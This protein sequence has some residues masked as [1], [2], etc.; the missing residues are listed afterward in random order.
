[1]LAQVRP[2]N[3]RACYES[4]ISDILL[5]EFSV[6]YSG[7]QICELFTENIQYIHGDIRPGRH[8][9]HQSERKNDNI[10][11]LSLPIHCQ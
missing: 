11:L 10:P 4:V 8:C 2:D 1:M 7:P 3:Y 9:R 5:E 6:S